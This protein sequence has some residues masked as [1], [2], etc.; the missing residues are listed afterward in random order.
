MTVL[1]GILAI[2]TLIGINAFYVAGEFALLAVDRNKVEALAADGSRSAKNL[3]EALARLSFHLSGA[4]LGITVTS[5]LVGIIAEPVFTPIFA[6]LLDAIGLGNVDT[7]AISATAGLII[8]TIAQMIFGELTPKNYALARALPT[9]LL[10]GGAMRWANVLL[11]PLIVLF[12][13]AA[14]ATIRLFG[15]EPREELRRGR[16]RSELAM[17][18]RSSAEGGELLTEEYGIIE[19]TFDFAVTTAGDALVPIA[20][21]VSVDNTDPITTL[22]DRA[23]QSG[24]SR[25]PVLRAGTSDIVGIVHVKDAFGVARPE[26]D[27]TQVSAIAHD[28][29][30]VS[31]SVLLGG[32]VVGMRERSEQIA[33]VADAYGSPVGIITMED[34]LEEIV[35]DIEDEFDIDAAGPESRGASERRMRGQR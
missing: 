16:S 34:L 5:L 21:I 29:Y 27:R 2:V 28:P 23:R 18:I 20:D 12:N 4:Q 7:P 30:V 15:I 3:L 1:L 31:S 8:S 32:L 19:R 9:A 14:N 26:R 6:P 10:I 33:I 17:L 35:G 11:T 13:G 25:L 24:H 22:I